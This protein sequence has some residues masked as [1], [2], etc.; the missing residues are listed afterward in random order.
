MKG[1]E[2]EKQGKSKNTKIK[3]DANVQTTLTGKYETVVAWTNLDNRVI[4]W[5]RLVR[6]GQVHAVVAILSG[7][8]R[9]RDHGS[10][11]GRW[12]TRTNKKS[13]HGG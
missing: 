2:P 1:W 6:L 13:E 12:R 8:Q 9:R 5:S 4:F 7:T 11:S 3:S 10:K